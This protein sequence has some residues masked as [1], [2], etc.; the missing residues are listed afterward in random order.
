M[1]NGLV[2]IEKC[3]K[4]GT[5]CC[6]GNIGDRLETELACQRGGDIAF[7]DHAHLFKDLAKPTA[8][9]PVFLQSLLQLV[10]V[11]NIGFKQD[12]PET[13]VP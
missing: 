13:L 4:L 1:F 10:L 9:L 8:G 3:Q 6:L 2:A 11:N 7:G 12:F 5:E